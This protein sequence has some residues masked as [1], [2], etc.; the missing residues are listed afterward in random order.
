[1]DSPSNRIIKNWEEIFWTLEIILQ[2]VMVQTQESVKTF[3]I[4][5]SVKI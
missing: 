1:M 4:S 5:A 3:A 2:T